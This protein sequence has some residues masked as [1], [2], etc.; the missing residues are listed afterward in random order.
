MDGSLSAAAASRP[1]TWSVLVAVGALSG[2]LAA[3]VM[4]WPMSRQPDGFMPAAIAAGILTRQSVD[5]VSMPELLA[6]HHVAGLLAGGLYGVF[7]L[8]A[9]ANL[10]AVGSIAGLNLLAHLLAVGV[11]TGFI[12][13]FFAHLVLPRA[14][15]RSYEEQATAIRGQWLRSSL[16]FGATLLVAVPLIVL[17]LAG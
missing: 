10:P 4:D 15:G 5:E 14:S 6:V 7:V 16:V 13:G 12:Y 8:G 9:T 17:S 2:L 3:V 1:I 11:V